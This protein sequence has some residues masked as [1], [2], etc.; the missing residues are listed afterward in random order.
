[1]RFLWTIVSLKAV[2]LLLFLQMDKNKKEKRDK[3]RENEKE[4]RDKER[5]NEKE[6]SSLAKEKVVKKRQS[7]PSMRIRPDPRYTKTLPLTLTLP[8][9]LTH[10]P[11]PPWTPQG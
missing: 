1:M 4:K 6:K 5:E 9:S 3:E 10:Q 7:M 2:H 11:P 8:L